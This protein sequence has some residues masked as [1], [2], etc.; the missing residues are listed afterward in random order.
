MEIP[1]S[2]MEAAF[3][4]CLGWRSG[5]PSKYSIDLYTHSEYLASLVYAPTEHQFSALVDKPTTENL[6]ACILKIE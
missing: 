4:C 1:S 5:R 2:S 3:S 6:S